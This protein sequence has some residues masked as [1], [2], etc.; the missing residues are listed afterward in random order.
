MTEEEILQQGIE[1]QKQFIANVGV[2]DVAYASGT[3]KDL[4]ANSLLVSYG[5][6]DGREDYTSN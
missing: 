6:N 5:D 1:L 2:L 4:D 3:V